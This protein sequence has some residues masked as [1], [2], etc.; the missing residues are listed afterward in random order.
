MAADLLVTTTLMM[1]PA[2]VPAMLPV[3]YLP[4]HY[5][6]IGLGIVLGLAIIAG[7]F[8]ALQAMRLQIAVA[9]RKNG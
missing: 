9:L 8:P 7:I 5:I 3:F 2:T 6:F 4:L 1:P